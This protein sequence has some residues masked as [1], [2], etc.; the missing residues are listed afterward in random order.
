MG[1]TLR[2]VTLD[3]VVTD[4]GGAQ[5]F[6]VRP[7]FRELEAAEHHRSGRQQYFPLRSWK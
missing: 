6:A 2:D 1:P 5:W 4:M 7:Q 3:V